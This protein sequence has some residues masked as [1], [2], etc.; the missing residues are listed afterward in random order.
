MSFNSYYK[1]KKITQIA[2]IPCWHEECAAQPVEKNLQ[3][4]II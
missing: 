2:E 4:L 3:G 1:P